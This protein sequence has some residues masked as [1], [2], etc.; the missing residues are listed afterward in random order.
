[1]PG[2]SK[3][4]FLHCEDVSGLYAHHRPLGMELTGQLDMRSQTSQH[5]CNGSL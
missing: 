3:N 5:V 2:D 1:M 4:V